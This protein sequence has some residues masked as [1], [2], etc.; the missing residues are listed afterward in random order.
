MC[1]GSYGFFGYSL[2]SPANP[3]NP[4]H[5]DPNIQ[6]WSIY[7]S[8][9]PPSR[10]LAHEVVRDQLLSR[11]GSWKSPYDTADARIYENIINL[12]CDNSNGTLLILPRYVVPRLPKWTTPSGKIILIGDAAHAMPPDSGQGVS[13]AAEDAV[14]LSLLLKHFLVTHEFAAS[15]GLTRTAKAF[16]EVRM[17]RVGKILDIAKRN[18]DNKK[19]IGWFMEKIRDWFMWFFCTSQ[20]LPSYI[21]LIRVATLLGKLPESIHDGVFGY[22]TEAEVEKYLRKQ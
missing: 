2:I 9:A 16:E 12:G 1:F 20:D 18:G 3:T 11:H 6:W 13:C 5:N 4:D 8:P 17:G 21:V 14:A 15:E 10:S 19:K 22:D 7:E